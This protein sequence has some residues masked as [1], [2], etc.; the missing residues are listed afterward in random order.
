MGRPRAILPNDCPVCGYFH[1][2]LS[3]GY[4]SRSEQYVWIID[5]TIPKE[6]RTT[7]RK[8]QQCIFRMKKSKLHRF[9]RNIDTTT[10]RLL[11]E[12]KNPVMIKLKI[13]T[14]LREDIMRNGWGLL[15]TQ[16]KFKQNKKWMTFRELLLQYPNFQSLP[17]PMIEF[18]KLLHKTRNIR[19]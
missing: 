13:S 14:A 15:M 11:S 6:L 10:K 17:K 4:Y 7:K 16:S 19:D 9:F 2:S 18:Y 12:K 5:H 3:L 8:R 1:G